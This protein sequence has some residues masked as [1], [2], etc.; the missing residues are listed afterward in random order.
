ASILTADSA[1]G[2]DLG[3][4]N[5]IG[6]LVVTNDGGNVVVH[7]LG[8][9]EIAGINQLSGG[10]VLVT[11]DGAIQVSGAITAE[12]SVDLAAAGP[13]AEPRRAPDPA[14]TL[15]ADSAGGIDL[16]GDNRIGVLVVTNDG[17][18]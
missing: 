11:N 3:A 16:G 1:G 5:R 14:S 9:L 18:D 6:V 4:D 13:I 15:T 17:G 8:D 7:N 10:N 2:I 12:G